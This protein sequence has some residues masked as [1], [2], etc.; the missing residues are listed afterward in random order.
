[1]ISVG[2]YAALPAVQNSLSIAQDAAISAAMTRTAPPTQVV[3]VQPPPPG[4]DVG[5]TGGRPTGNRAGPQSARAEALKD[6]VATEEDIL[7]RNLQERLARDDYQ[8]SERASRDAEA[9]AAYAAISDGSRS[10][11]DLSRRV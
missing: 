9:E 8:R 7:Q 5:G 2:N 4:G 6:R 3:A 1:M 11:M 10:S